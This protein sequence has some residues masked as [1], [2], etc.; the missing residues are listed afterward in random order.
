MVLINI[1][2]MP[3]DPIKR[4]YLVTLL[5]R[6]C[7][8]YFRVF[9]F[10]KDNKT[11]LERQRLENINTYINNIYNINM[12]IYNLINSLFDNLSFN[13]KYDA[14][15]LKDNATI[16]GIKASHLFKLIT[17]GNLECDRSN[18]IKRCIEQGFK[19]AIIENYKLRWS[20]KT[21]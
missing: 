10:S 12:N 5:K 17:Y 11:K 9:A 8:K 4:D 3:T 20:W 16:F 1:D 6:N 14:L 19:M 7:K 18:I 13:A 2:N 15:M 21:T